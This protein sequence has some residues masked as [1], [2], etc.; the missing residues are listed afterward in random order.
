MSHLPKQEKNIQEKASTY[1]RLKTDL[2]K[3]TFSDECK[4]WKAAL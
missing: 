4:Q 1:I 3:A 2:I